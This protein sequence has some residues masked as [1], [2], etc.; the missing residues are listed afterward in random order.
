MY[1]G[2]IWGQKM[3][4]LRYFKLEEVENAKT[5]PALLSPKE[6]AQSKT[7]STAQECHQGLKSFSHFFLQFSWGL[8]S[9]AA[10]NITASRQH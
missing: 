3:D 1:G 10:L 5:K 7:W 4:V 6:E 2:I 9:I 8:S